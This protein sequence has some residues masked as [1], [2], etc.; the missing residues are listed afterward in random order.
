MSTK[1]PGNHWLAMADQLDLFAPKVPPYRCGWNEC[2]CGIVFWQAGRE[3]PVLLPFRFWTCW[4]GIKRAT[5][6]PTMDWEREQS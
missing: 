3:C 4:R 6:C 1:P 2:D 5:H